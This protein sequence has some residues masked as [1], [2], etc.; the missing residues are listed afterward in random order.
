[1]VAPSLAQSRATAS[2][3]QAEIPTSPENLE[4]CGGRG[5]WLMQQYMSN[6]VYNSRGNRVTLT[7]FNEKKSSDA[8]PPA[9]SQAAMG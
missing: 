2:P 1:M 4:R 8:S 7:K 5:V 6:V 3:F 9:Q